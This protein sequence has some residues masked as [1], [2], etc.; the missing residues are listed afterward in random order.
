MTF[1]EE[2]PAHLQVDEL[3]LFIQMTDVASGFRCTS[4]LQL[5]INLSPLLHHSHNSTHA[6]HHAIGQ[7]EELLM[8]RINSLQL[9]WSLI[10]NKN[11]NGIPL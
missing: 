9:I 11:A 10:I 1:A 6:I 8:S 2:T 4:N 5:T 3:G 7:P